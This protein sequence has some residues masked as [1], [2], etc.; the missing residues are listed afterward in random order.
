MPSGVVVTGPAFDLPLGEYKITAQPLQPGSHPRCRGSLWGNPRVLSTA[1]PEQTTLCFFPA[2]FQPC[3]HRGGDIPWGMEMLGATVMVAM[4]RAATIPLGTRAVSVW[5][6]AVLGTWAARAE[7]E[8][9]G[10]LD[11]LGSLFSPPRLSVLTGKQLPAQ[12]LCTR[13]SRTPS[14]CWEQPGVEAQGVLSSQQYC[15]VVVPG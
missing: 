6:Q 4:A 13:W 8:V 12:G 5:L 7:L 14:S 15:G 9:W 3:L 11:L 10:Q 1:P 2:V